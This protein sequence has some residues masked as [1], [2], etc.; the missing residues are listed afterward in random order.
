MLDYTS[1]ASRVGIL[2]A[3]VHQATPVR[4]LDDTREELSACHG[5]QQKVRRNAGDSAV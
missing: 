5:K 2:Q 3:N 1:L 4:P